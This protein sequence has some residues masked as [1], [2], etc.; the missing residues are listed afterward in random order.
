MNKLLINKKEF[1]YAAFRLSIITIALIGIFAETENSFLGQF[2]FFTLQTNLFVI[3]LMLTK[4]IMQILSIF[5]QGYNFSN[6]VTFGY[7]KISITFYITITGTI[8][9]FVLVP[10]ALATNSSFVTD[11]SYRDIF[12]HIFVPLLTIIEYCSCEE[13]SLLKK[14]YA[15]ILLAYPI[16]YVVSIFIRALLGGKPFPGGSK[17]PYFFIDP[18]FNSQ[19]WPM[20][21][22]YCIMLITSFYLLALLF[23]FINNKLVKKTT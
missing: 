4:I 10:V 16:V 22:F 19:G 21:F 6:S 2:W 8:F 14:R 20:V 1:L 11:L 5:N 7:V 9:C 15:L 17:Y 18:T 23:I 3:I 12:L 13:K